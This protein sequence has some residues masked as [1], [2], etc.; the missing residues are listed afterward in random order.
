MKEEISELDVVA[1]T[2]DVPGQGLVSGQVGTVVEVRNLELGIVS[3]GW[4]DV[5]SPT[6]H[7]VSRKNI[8]A[9]AFESAIVS[10][11]MR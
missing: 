11:S 3:D 9:A 1:L 4:P 10:S 5:Q 7:F 6:S 2:E 8:N